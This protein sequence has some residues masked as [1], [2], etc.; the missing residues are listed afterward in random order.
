MELEQVLSFPASE[1][2]YP[3]RRLLLL[4]K[5]FK[6]SA[7]LDLFYVIYELSHGSV[8][9][10]PFMLE[11]EV[12]RPITQQIEVYIIEDI[13]KYITGHFNAISPGIITFII[14]HSDKNPLVLSRV[15]IELTN[16][17]R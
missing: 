16:L 12:T 9:I 2:K 1:V 4:L 8:F 6:Y 15:V 14:S 11:I 17:A 5:V 7:D 10:S 13:C 3:N